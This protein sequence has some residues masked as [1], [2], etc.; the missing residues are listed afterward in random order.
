MSDVQ[1]K[2]K[3]T[4]TNL[5]GYAVAMLCLLAGF[6]VGYL[7]RGSAPKSIPTTSSPEVRQS[8][9]SNGANPHG[10][11]QQ[12]P[13]PEQIRKTAEQEAAPL[14]EQFKEHPNDGSLAARIGDLYYDAQMFPAAVEY[15]QKSLAINNK[16]DNVRT[17][18][19]TSLFNSNQTDEALVEI[20]RVL[21]DDPNNYTALFNRGVMRWQGK[22][23]TKGAISDW[24]SIL[25]RNPNYKEVEK[26]RGF[27]ARAK[28]TTDRS[29]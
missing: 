8:G 18:L 10:S 5:Q 28:K 1:R 20:D 29:M 26:V 25:R 9:V 22:M 7:Y 16:N 2:S 27:I 12:P 21:H 14:I 24:E 3:R 6:A 11:V 15:F 17:D 13:T 19:A 23:D 4:Q